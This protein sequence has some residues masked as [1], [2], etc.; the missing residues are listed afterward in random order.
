M[1][2]T[3][4]LDLKKVYKALYS[5]T[6]KP[7]LVEVPPLR[8]LA[9]D[10]S[11]DPN[12]S[13]L[14]AAAVEALFTVAYTLKFQVKKA[15]G[16]DFAV[17]PLEGLWW[18]D[19]MAAFCASRKADWKWTLL[20]AQPDFVSDDAVAAAIRAAAGKKE[21]PALAGMRLEIMP[22]GRAAQVL[23][24]GPYSEEGPTIAALHRFIAD[25]G[26]RP[27]GKHQE[28]YLSDA[29]RTAPDK[30]RTIL[31]QPVRSAVEGK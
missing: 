8:Y 21:L 15:G 9:A 23:H 5:A 4:K 28:I 13:P 10:G 11:G 6:A 3:D 7:A 14:F 25:Q 30:L 1:D 27:D 12:G 19:D 16:P 31:R 26:L 24:V 29:R 22:G 20:I 17:M 2:M 18:A